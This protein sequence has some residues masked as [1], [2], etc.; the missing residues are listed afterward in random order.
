MF[1]E[2]PLCS[3]PW[4]RLRGSHRAKTGKISPSK[5]LKGLTVHWEIF[6]WERVG[7]PLR[8]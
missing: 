6:R 7:G 8:R 1:A 3:R 5:G 4:A 2:H